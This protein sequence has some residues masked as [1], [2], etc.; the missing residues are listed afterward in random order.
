MADLHERDRGDRS[1]ADRRQSGSKFPDFESRNF[2]KSLGVVNCKC[3]ITGIV[4]T[5]QTNPSIQGL[6][7]QP[8]K[9]LGK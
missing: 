3:V 7:S 2:E 5:N 1:H 8:N 4:G 9:Y 6:D